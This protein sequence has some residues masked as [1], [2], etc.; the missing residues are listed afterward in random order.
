MAISAKLVSVI[1]PAYNAAQ[2]IVKTLDSVF[3]QTYK[4]LEVIVVNDGSTDDTLAVLK[5]YP[6]SINVVSTENKGVSYARSLGFKHTKGDYLQYLDADDLLMC[7]KIEIQVQALTT[8]NAD[9]AYGDWQKFKAENNQI[10]ITETIEREIEGD[11]EIALFT[12]FWCPPAAILYSKEICQNIEWNENLPVIQDARYFLDAAIAKGK[13][14]YTKGIMAKY[15]TAQLNSLSQK[16]DLNFVQ[17]L[18]KNTKGV[19][20]IWKADLNDEKKTVVIKSLRHCINRLSVLDKGLAKGAIE[21]LLKIEP[22][23]LPPEKGLLRALSKIIGYKS[24]EKVAGF[25][26]AIKL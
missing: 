23:Y 22:H 15:R 25:K 8:Q 12:Y 20:T 21:F 1:I 16:S 9:V 6:N 13:F 4:N 11:L 17:D 14:V 7:E 18:Y 3:A 5:N 10:T 24:A 2:T 26:R 19:Y